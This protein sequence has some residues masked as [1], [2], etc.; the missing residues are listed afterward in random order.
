ME[1]KIQ[2]IN[3]ENNSLASTN[4]EP[5]RN[6]LFKILKNQRISKKKQDQIL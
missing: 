6:E 2:K 4:Y 1:N 3:K 5:L